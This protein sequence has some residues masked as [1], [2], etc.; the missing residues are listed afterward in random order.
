MY[1]E[2]NVAVYEL[3]NSAR[4]FTKICPQHYKCKFGPLQILVHIFLH[5]ETTR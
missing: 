1:F 2:I 5:M 3:K 4:L